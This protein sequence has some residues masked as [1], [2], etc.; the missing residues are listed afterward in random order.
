MIQVNFRVKFYV[1]DPERLHEE[2]TRYQFYLQVKKDLLTT[3]LPCS[4]DSQAL[5]GAHIIQGES[6]GKSSI[7]SFICLFVCLFEGVCF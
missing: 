4:L 3:R 6:G 2:L 1:T 5:L 7:Y